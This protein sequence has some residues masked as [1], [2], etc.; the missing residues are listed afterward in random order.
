[1]KLQQLK[2]IHIIPNLAKG[3]AERI[4]LD[5]CVELQKLGHEVIL[6][7]FENINEYEDISKDISCQ[8]VEISKNFSVRNYE[9]KEFQ[10]LKKIVKE[11]N[12]DVVHTH[13]FA[14]EIVWKLTGIKI[15]SIFHI[16]DNI[17]VFHP[18]KEGVLKKASWVKWYEKTKYSGLLKT[19]PTC[20]LC[21]SKDTYNFITYH[22]AQKNGSKIKLIPNAIDTN[23]F[24]CQIRSDLTSI[25]LVTVGSL[26]LNKGH[27]LLF[28]VV[29]ELKKLTNKNVSLTVVGDGIEKERLLRISKE[30]KIEKNIFFTGKVNNPEEYLRR[31]NFYIH[32]SLSESFGLVLIEAMASGLPVFSTDGGG[33]RDLI[34]NGRN[35]YIYSSRNPKRIAKDIYYLSESISKYTEIAQS[36]LDFSQSYDIKEYGENLVQLYNTLI[37][38]KI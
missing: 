37:A 33:N 11:F 8:L 1:M 26:V 9:S 4:C 2:I 20:F 32:G 28:N 21:I 6:I 15:P 3:G 22:I 10:S 24:K 18:F 27:E 38:E 17:K 16:H 31:S 12:P 34:E 25:N 14:A 36:G 29:L 30:L 13:L 35:G 5:I 19:Q 7:L 23:K